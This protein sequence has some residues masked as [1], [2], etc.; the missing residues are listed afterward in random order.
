M[1]TKIQALILIFFFFVFNTLVVSK[2]ALAD[3]SIHVRLLGT[4]SPTPSSS[5]FGMSTLIEAGDQR[6]LFDMGRGATIRLWQLQVPFGSI[7][8]HFITHMHSDHLNG[9]PDLW[10][11]GWISTP[12]G[13]RKEPMQIYGPHGTK[14]MMENLRKAFVDDIR[15]RTEDEHNPDAGIAVDAHDIESGFIY[16]KNG[17][18]VK[19]FDVNHGDL[20]KPS[21]GYKITYKGHSV[22]LS[23]D[24]K[25]DTRVENEAQ[26]VD[27]L[28]HEVALIPPKLLELHSIFSAIYAHHTNPEEAGRLFSAARPKMAVYSHLVLS[29][30]PKN[31]IPM[32][33]TEALIDAT[34]KT[35]DGP[36]TVGQD[37]LGFDIDDHGVRLIPFKEK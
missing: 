11:T 5:R 19:A 3:D 27:L 23:G 2:S 18:V 29:S 4:G 8:A 22:V 17:V 33:T 15:I 36:L 32:P 35:Y 1:L 7:N 6:L 26:G 14:A 10:L 12:Y 13:G 24:T 25:Y 16:E 31:G 20:I 28:V 21:F 30:D 9:L 34:R 37:L